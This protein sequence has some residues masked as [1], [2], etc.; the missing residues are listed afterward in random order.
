[1]D[2]QSGE[3][4]DEFHRRVKFVVSNARSP[5]RRRVFYKYRYVYNI[6]R[7]ALIVFFHLQKLI[8]CYGNYDA[9]CEIYFGFYYKCSHSGGFFVSLS[10]T[11]L[12]CSV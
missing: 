11:I 4:N 5:Y 7:V 2:V 8:L 1:M 9:R 3:T 10:V 12:Y 6:V